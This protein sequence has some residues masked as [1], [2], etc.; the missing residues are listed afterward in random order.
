[1]LMQDD[2]RA[3]PS[4]LRLAKATMRTVWLNV[5]FAVGIKLAFFALVLAGLGSMWLAV[6]ADVGASLLVTLN[7]MRLRHRVF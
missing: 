7:G 1:V 5:A 4:L 2:L 6:F 3:L